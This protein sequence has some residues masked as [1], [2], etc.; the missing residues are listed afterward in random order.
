MHNCEPFQ[1]DLYYD[2]D[3]VKE[4]VCL[5]EKARTNDADPKKNADIICKYSGKNIDIQKKWLKE[6]K[7][8]N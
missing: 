4:A 6:F 2:K 3:N 1:N 7:R 8:L 5:L